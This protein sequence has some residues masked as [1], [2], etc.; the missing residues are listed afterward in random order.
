MNKT[1][2]DFEAD[3]GRKYT[4][5]QITISIENVIAEGG[6]GV[7]FLARNTSKNQKYALKRLYVNEETTLSACK[8]EIQIMSSLSSH[9]N[10]VT[11]VA[12]SITRNYKGVWEVLILMQ[13]YPGSCMKLLNERGSAGLKEP[14][15]LKIFCDTCEAVAR[16]HHCQKPIIHRD[17]KMENILAENDGTFV[18]CDFGS[19]T[20]RF[21]VPGQ[22][23]RSVTEIEDDINKHTTLSHRAPEMINLY[24]QKSITTKADIWA[25]GV[26]LFRLCFRTL[27]FGESTLAIQ[28]GNINI[29]EN[30]PYSRGLHALACYCLQADPDIRPDIYQVSHVAFVLA[31]RNCPVKDIHNSPLP[32]VNKLV[33]TMMSRTAKASHS[34]TPKSTEKGSRIEQTTTITPRERPKAARNASHKSQAP[35][36]VQR[37]L[38]SADGVNR[39]AIVLPTFAQLQQSG[40]PLQQQ[41]YILQQQQI[42]IER[43]QLHFFKLQ[44]V[45]MSQTQSVQQQ[46]LV[47]EVSQQLQKLALQVQQLAQL[48][49][50]VTQ[51]DQQQLV[52]QQLA[53]QQLAQQQLA[54]Q[55]LAVQVQQE[56][57]ARQQLSQQALYEQQQLQQQYL[58]QAIQQHPQQYIHVGERQNVPD[59]TQ[60]MYQQQQQQQFYPQEQCQLAAEPEQQPKDEQSN[61]HQEE[62]KP[63][64]HAFD[65]D[66]SESVMFEADFSP[67]NFAT[68][69]T[70]SDPECGQ[71]LSSV[72][73]RLEEN[74]SIDVGISEKPSVEAINKERSTG[75]K[76]S[77]SLTPPLVLPKRSHRRNVS[78]TSVI[79]IG[80]SNSAF[81]GLVKS[82]SVEGASDRHWNPFADESDSISDDVMFGQEF[83][84]LRCGSQSSIQ[85]VKSREDLVMFENGNLPQDP[86][87]AAPFHPRNKS[88][89]AKREQK[90]AERY[91]RLS[92]ATSDENLLDVEIPAKTQNQTI[93]GVPIP[94]TRK[95]DRTDKYHKVPTDSDTDSLCNKDD[96]RSSDEALDRTFS[97]SQYRQ[98]EGEESSNGGTLTRSNQSV[99]LF[100]H[101]G[102]VC[103]PHSCESN[104]SSTITPPVSSSENLC[105]T[106]GT[107]SFPVGVRR[108]S[109]SAAV[110]ER[111]VTIPL[112][113]TNP[114]LAGVSV[115]TSQTR[116]AAD[117]VVES[118]STPSLPSPAGLSTPKETSQ[119]SFPSI[120]TPT[121]SHTPQEFSSGQKSPV[122]GGSTAFVHSEGPQC[123]GRMSKSKTLDHIQS[124]TL[125]GPGDQP[126][127]IEP[128][129]TLK[130]SQTDYEV[131]LSD[132][133]FE[134]K[135]QNISD[136]ETLLTETSGSLRK[137][138]KGRKSPK[139]S[140][141]VRS[142]RLLESKKGLIYDGDGEY[143]GA[144]TNEAFSEQE[145]QSGETLEAPSPATVPVLKPNPPAS[146]KPSTDW[147][148]PIAAKPKRKQSAESPPIVMLPTQTPV[149][150]VQVETKTVSKSATKAS[151]KDPHKTHKR[152]SSYDLATGRAELSI[153]ADSDSSK[154]ALVGKESK[155]KKKTKIGLGIF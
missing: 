99:E 57:L 80:T 43:E 85:N 113:S 18:L 95:T 82:S 96:T 97:S 151:S 59:H 6:F 52:Q 143:E 117:I 53:Q 136:S 73:E 51:T 79:S 37:Q 48:Q 129:K 19:A 104:Y 134:D 42:L 38:L 120:D 146:P 125:A 139:S 83:D 17:L 114:F 142:P 22:D 70:I 63:F 105:D 75:N 9:K 54:Q 115:S 101:N 112:H 68:S 7:V 41:Q 130:R 141:S 107:T 119:K 132:I 2:S 124:H 71:S 84:R 30:S 4:L 65:D 44:K 11:F 35:P 69:V 137:R 102:D 138:E 20:A 46:S 154:S 150:T 40:Y 110:A 93:F 27:P 128:E 8:R 47:Q 60:Y 39:P 56:N 126:I 90:L 3:I 36:D 50:Q 147:K 31:N 78:D 91:S 33:E 106:L 144:L 25:L 121:A 81:R 152:Y 13:Y 153:C 133:N 24:G 14:E 103:R 10:M 100:S 123:L 34:S 12:S 148:P 49:Q 149:K 111:P 29:P 131:R 89:Q 92:A 94:F 32:D 155:S 66:F 77:E 55:Q 127:I 118:Q 86:F 16:L 145:T 5:D 21:Y 122:G 15:V 88:R 108:D 116:R 74:S 140:R 64:T 76:P 109:I 72:T 23:E 1:S 45:I 58:Q 61:V 26:T 62:T 87:G 135:T 67:A 98:L 28:T